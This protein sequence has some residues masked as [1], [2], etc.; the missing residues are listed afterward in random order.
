MDGFDLFIFFR[1][2][3]LIFA[4]TYSVLMLSSGIWRVVRLFG[5]ENPRKQML[6]LYVSYQLVTI[7]LRP[8]RGELLQL[9]LLLVMLVCIWRLHALI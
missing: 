6:R 3:L 7:R 1:T 8:V 4:T 5:G 2:T 9:A